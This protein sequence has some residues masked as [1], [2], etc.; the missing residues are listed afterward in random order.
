M[1]FDHS[2]HGLG[3]L[4]GAVALV[5]VGIFLVGVGAAAFPLALLDPLWQLRLSSA[6]NTNAG[7]LLTS[8]AFLFVAAA[9][10]PKSLRLQSAL[11]RARRWAV[12]ASLCFFLLVPLQVVI[13]WRLDSLSA[14]AT[15][16]Q[17]ATFEQR[18]GDLRRQVGSART[19]DQIQ[20]SLVAFGAPPLSPVELGLPTTQLQRRVRDALTATDADLKRRLSQVRNQ[21]RTPELVRGSIR[22]MVLSLL[23]ALGFAAG[24]V[25]PGS[26]RT[27]LEEILGLLRSPLRLY[28]R[29]SFELA[30]SLEDL[31]E[32]RQAAE[33]RRIRERLQVHREQEAAGLHEDQEP[34]PTKPRNKPAQGW[35][36]GIGTGKPPLPDED[37]IRR[38]SD[39]QDEKP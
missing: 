12:L 13:L 19:N 24:A 16:R 33:A 8:F 5:F 31:Q 30:S 37:Y 2:V 23:F 6:I 20:A 18:L 27:L 36:M 11:H 14:S 21:A 10:Q 32:R 17:Q 39:D 29:A 26:H 38:I 15:R 1:Q 25:L 7:F 22:T 9:L 4:L 28:Q 35:R 34:I 3:R